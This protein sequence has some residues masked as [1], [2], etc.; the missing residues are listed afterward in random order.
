[1]GDFLLVKCALNKGDLMFV[2][3]T[4]ASLAEVCRLDTLV[5]IT[6]L[7]PDTERLLMSNDTGLP[8]YIM[9]SNVFC[10]L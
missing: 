9:N 8:L 5:I 7:N 6:T 2:L 10:S 3:H 1:M 4:K